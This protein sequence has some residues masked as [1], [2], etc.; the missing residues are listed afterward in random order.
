L[1]A[2]AK[3]TECHAPVIWNLS[4]IM[5]ALTRGGHLVEMFQKHDGPAR[6]HRIA[7]RF[8]QVQVNLLTVLTF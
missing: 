3:V 2:H 6:G 5:A 4:V 8:D 7:L 1:G